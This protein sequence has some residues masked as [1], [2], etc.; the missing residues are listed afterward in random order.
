VSQGSSLNSNGAQPNHELLPTSAVNSRYKSSAQMLNASLLA[1]STPQSLYQ[2]N[3][4]GGDSSLIHHVLTSNSQSVVG[5]LNVV[6]SVNSSWAS[7]HPVSI[8]SGYMNPIETG[9][10]LVTLEIEKN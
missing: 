5:P 10:H 6:G 3:V 1:N 2:P 4:A 7:E 9:L 8:P